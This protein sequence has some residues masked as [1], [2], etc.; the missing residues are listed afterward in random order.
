MAFRDM[1]GIKEGYDSGFDN[2]LNDF[3]IPILK[4]AKNYKRIAG[5]FSSSSLAVA[6]RGIAGLIENGG[7]MDMLVSPRLSEEDL[8][9]MEKAAKSPEEIIENSLLIEFDRVETALQRKR[10]AALGWLL[11]Q[12]LLNIKVATVY[13]DHGRIL[14][15]EKIEESGLFHIKVGVLEDENGDIITFSGSVNE[16][17]SAWVKNIEEFKVFKQWE[18]GQSGQAQIDIEKFDKYW[19]GEAKRVKITELPVAVAE[20]IIEKAPEKIERLEQEIIEEEQE[21]EKNR[22]ELSFEPFYYQLEALEIWKKNY[23]A[24]FEMATGTGKTKTA[25]VCIADFIKNADGPA[26]VFIICPQ[27]T[28][29][30]QWL[31]DIK[32]SGLPWDNYVICDS[33]SRGWNGSGPNSLMYKLLDVNVER[34]GKKNVLFVYST[35]DTYYGD[36]FTSTVIQY[37]YGA[38]YFI[39]GDE[40]HGLGSSQRAKGFLDIYD[41]RLGLS[42][43]PDRW[44]DDHGTKMISDFFGEDRFSFTIEQA[45][46]KKNPITGKTYLTPFEYIPRFVSLEADELIKYKKLTASIIRGLGKAKTDSDYAD[47]I[48]NLMFMRADI[49]KSAANKMV[50]FEKILDELDNDVSDTIVFVSPGQIEEV[51]VILRK[52][53][54]LTRRFT[55]DQGKSPE[56]RY[57]NISEREHIIQM[58]KD[59]DCKCLLAIKCLDEGIDIPSAKLAIILASST[60]PRE[61]VQRI[62]RIIRRSPGKEKAVLYDV[63]VE[64]SLDQLDPELAKYERN[65]F[66]KEMIR[67]G[68]I[69]ENAT[70]RLD[71]IDAVYERLL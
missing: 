64:P 63:I 55:K 22:I 48:E 12:G 7:H 27:D 15:Y 60:N 8:K 40:V 28:L 9:M 2:I 42:A 65:I 17:A 25:Q 68:E 56:K 20:K 16:T 36:T 69:S 49:H 4:N 59:G 1:D 30:K 70:N 35:F 46:T 71:I 39:I 58:F 18:P 23:K 50:E 6:A 29:A 32:D 24:I 47:K 52:R 13:D 10:V 43:T 45:L 44:F 67:I 61:Y 11:A 3:Y 38:K 53:G 5:F 33:D 21:E 62:G 26:V 37:K 41:Y 34:A 14:D 57:G 66:E 19:N 31:N 51:E 54:I